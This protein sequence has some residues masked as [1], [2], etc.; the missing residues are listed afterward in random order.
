ME[1]SQGDYNI[2]GEELEESLFTVTSNLSVTA[3]KSSLV[4]CLASV[5]A[6]PTPLKSGVRLT[7]GE[8][9]TL[10]NTTVHTQITGFQ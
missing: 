5:S 6:L 4:D 1:L 3:T 2:T 10:Y 8:T 7:V 9:R